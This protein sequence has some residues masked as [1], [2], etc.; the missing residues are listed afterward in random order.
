M[1]EAESEQNATAQV[2]TQDQGLSGQ[3]RFG[4]FAGVFT[5]SVLTILGVI[6]YLRVGWVTGQLGL[7]GAIAVIL[8]AHL[9]TVATGLSVSSIATNR[10]VG[11]GGAY[12]I[13]SRSLGAPAGAAIGIPLFLA[14][15]LSVAFYVVGFT[16][17]INIFLSNWEAEL[18]VGLSKLLSSCATG[19]HT[20]RQA[21]KGL[22]GCFPIARNCVDSGSD[23]N[24]EEVSVDS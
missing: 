9:I 12:N 23:K 18:G 1:S 4:T 8:L 3:R 22:H 5:P 7:L 6:M 19:H 16:E 14:Q 13:I 17:S 10:T 20:D 11:A 15:A 2:S 21:V 24:V